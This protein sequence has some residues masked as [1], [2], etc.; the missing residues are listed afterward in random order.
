MAKAN[1]PL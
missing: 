1:D